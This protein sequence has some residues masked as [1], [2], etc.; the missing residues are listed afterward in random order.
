MPLKE[1]RDPAVIVVGL[2]T[3]GAWVL[4]MAMIAL[5]LGFEQAL[6]KEGRFVENGFEK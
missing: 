6:G 3:S 2:K 5:R 1:E 4:S